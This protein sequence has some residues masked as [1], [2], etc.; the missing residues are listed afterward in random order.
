MPQSAAAGAQSVG[1]DSKTCCCTKVG[2]ITFT[3]SFEAYNGTVSGQ[4][5][6]LNSGNGSEFGFLAT[7]PN[8]EKSEIKL[9]WCDGTDTTVPN[10]RGGSG[11]VD[12]FDPKTKVGW[13]GAPTPMGAK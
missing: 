7:G 3:H 8:G 1:K 5:N 11:K 2:A 12:S 9:T 4:Q 10:P 6:S 13:Q